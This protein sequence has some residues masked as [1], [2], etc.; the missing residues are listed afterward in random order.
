MKRTLLAVFFL[1]CGPAGEGGP[2]PPTLPEQERLPPATGGGAGADAGTGSTSPDGGSAVDAGAAPLEQFVYPAWDREDVQPQSRRF[3]Q[4]YG[5]EVYRGR[6]V[7]VVL[8]EGFCTFCQG[9][10]VVA[11]QLQTQ[12]TAERR[13]IDVV[14][15]GD[16]NAS[17]FVRRT[18]LPLFRDGTPGRQAWQAMRSGASKHDTFVFAPNGERTFFWAG[19]YTGDANRWTTEVGAAARAVA[20]ANP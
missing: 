19:S 1:S 5:L 4:V 10:V 20:P 15:L 17:E 9:N 7:V 18:A 12:L 14:V 16:A 6:A 13:D 3:G 2:N 8:L 11:E